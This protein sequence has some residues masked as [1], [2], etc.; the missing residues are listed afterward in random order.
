[1]CLNN[2]ICGYDSLDRPIGNLDF[3]IED[4]DSC[5]YVEVE[6]SLKCD[7]HSLKCVQMNVRG[8]TS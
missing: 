5:G 4:N 8:I 1:M 7:K 3:V 6:K 2:C